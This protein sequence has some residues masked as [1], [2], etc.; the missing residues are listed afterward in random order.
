MHL[1]SCVLAL[2]CKP[3]SDANGEAATSYQRV[4]ACRCGLVPY[5]RHA[6]SSIDHIGVKLPA[7]PAGSDAGLQ[8]ERTALAWTRT[9][10]AFLVNAV[11]IA[12]AG[13]Q[14]GFEITSVLGAFLVLSA[15]AIVLVA[16]SRKQCPLS[17]T[18]ASPAQLLALAVLGAITCLIGAAILAAD[19]K[20]AT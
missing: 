10:M 5:L 9:G 11:L 4:R 6:P 1:R 16:K 7:R 19:L 3:N 2:A 20:V 14:R 12:R 17:R 8:A 15:V 18:T 13:I